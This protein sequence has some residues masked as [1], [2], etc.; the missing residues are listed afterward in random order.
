MK[1]EIPRRN[2]LDLSTP[3][4]LAIYNAME[5][6]EKAGADKR[7]TDA[8]NLLAQAKNLIAD[9]IE[10]I[11]VSQSTPMGNEVSEERI[12]DL[13]NK[14]TTTDIEWIA[15]AHGAGTQVI[16]PMDYHKIAKELYSLFQSGEK[17]SDPR[18]HSE[19][20][21]KGFNDIR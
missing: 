12:L 4:E 1:N 16:D 17:A 3:A 6:V 21:A 20:P 19:R 18:S 14:F 11:E 13:L 15:H 10:G 2:R 7:L 8:L 5:E 9:Y